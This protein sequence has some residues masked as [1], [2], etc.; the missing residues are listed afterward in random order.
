MGFELHKNAFGGQLRPDPLGES[1]YV[2]MRRR[3]I[4]YN[5]E[6]LVN[7]GEGNDSVKQLSTVTKVGI[8]VQFVDVHCS[9]NTSSPRPHCPVL[10]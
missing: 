10:T 2:L 6:I 5:V 1:T 7:I 3:I 8:M 9:L 4:P